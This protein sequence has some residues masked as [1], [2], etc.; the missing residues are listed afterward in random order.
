MKQ[1]RHFGK[2]VV[3]GSSRVKT[4]GKIL[5]RCI[6]VNVRWMDED[7]EID[8][9]RVDDGDIFTDTRP[10]QVVE[11]SLASLQKGEQSDVERALNAFVNLGIAP[12]SD[13]QPGILQLLET[14]R[15]QALMDSDYDVAEQQDKI[16]ASLRALGKAE[17][18]RSNKS[19]S[20]DM[21]F[22][23]W[24][25]L[26]RKQSEIN[27]KWDQKIVTFLDEMEQQEL[28][29]Q[30]KQ[31]REVDDFLGQW[32]DPAFVRQFGKPSQQ[33][34]LLRDQE[35]AMAVNRMYGEAREIKSFADKIQRE[36]T[37]AAQMRI[38]AQ[39]ATDRDRLSVKHEKELEALR[40]Y[41]ERMLQAMMTEKAK[42]L[43]PVQTA[44]SQIKAKRQ[45]P[46]R[47]PK[48]ASAKGSR[49]VSASVPYSPRTATR[50]SHFRSEKKTTLL[51]VVPVT[52][53]GLQ[54]MKKR[55]RIARSKSGAST[56]LASRTSM[57]GRSRLSNRY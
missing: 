31:D 27:A 53:A 39:M 8:G 1:N 47:L 56:R 55:Q 48:L 19:R 7:S 22:Q 3:M 18:Q 50:Y 45:P 40:A 23:R 28:E 52:D 37:E 5:P 10:P 34:L 54:E 24:Q 33:L 41:K 32:K 11:P 14:R 46:S 30:A 38:T 44:L 6:V 17:E 2:L 26:Q 49:V 12:P 43:R 15:V 42:E 4:Q 35:K 57:N 51:D 13:L 36:E 16:A 25:N 29:L 9:V 21:L 20:L